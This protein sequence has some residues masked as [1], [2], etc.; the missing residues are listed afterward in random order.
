MEN[1]AQLRHQY[2]LD[3]HLSEVNFVIEAYKTLRDRAPYSAD[4]VVA[5]LSGSFAFVL[6]DHHCNDVF[7]AAV[8][9]QTLLL[10]VRCC[11]TRNARSSLWLPASSIVTCDL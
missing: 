7:V 10:P 11:Q 8:S 2:G 5:S 4:Q 3:R 9:L 1:I 6:Y